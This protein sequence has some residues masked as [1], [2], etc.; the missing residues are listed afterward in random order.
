MVRPLPR[1]TVDPH[2]CGGQPCVRGLRI[3][4]ALV[5]RH[6]AAGHDAAQIVGDY[7]ELEAD[8]VLECLRY[9]AWLASGRTV[10]IPPAA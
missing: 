2:V 3:P 10:E 7:P 9:A 4:V 1:I 6:L 5:L 8:D